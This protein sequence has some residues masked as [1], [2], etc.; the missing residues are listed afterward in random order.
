MQLAYTSGVITF[1]VCISLPV[2]EAEPGL[3]HPMH[4]LKFACV[5]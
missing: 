3:D 4:M 1:A 5:N 2:S